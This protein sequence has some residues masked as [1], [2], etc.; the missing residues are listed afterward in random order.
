MPSNLSTSPLPYSDIALQLLGSIHDALF[1]LSDKF[2]AG[3]TVEDKD[4]NSF[5]SWLDQPRKYPITRGMNSHLTTSV[6]KSKKISKDDLPLRLTAVTKSAFYQSQLNIE[7][8]DRYKGLYLPSPLKIL[9]DALTIPNE[10]QSRAYSLITCRNILF[11]LLSI[12]PDSEL[13]RQEGVETFSPKDINSALSK[14]RTYLEH[15]DN[16]SKSNVDFLQNKSGTEKKVTL[17]L[18]HFLAM[19]GILL[20]R[21]GTKG[22]KASYS[23]HDKNNYRLTYCKHGDL[24][25]GDV[26]YEFMQSP[27]YLT[28]PRH[29]ELINQIWGIPLPI[30]G[31]DILFH[32]GLL[33]SS[34]GSLV[35][36]ICGSAGTGKTS[37]ALAIA[38][39]LSPLG[40]STYYITFEENPAD[41]NLRV[42]SL[43]PQYLK[44]LSIYQSDH[45]KWFYADKI[46]MPT[47]VEREKTLRESVTS[48]LE[49]IRE[50][51]HNLRQ[52]RN[53][54][55]IPH[56]CPLVVVIDG[57][58]VLGENVNKSDDL[59]TYDIL[60]ELVVECRKLN[61]MVLLLSGE[62]NHVVTK[63]DYL[64]DTVISL[65]HEG[66]KDSKEKAVRI[67][68]LSKTRQQI[69][70]PGAHVF[71]MSGDDGFRISPQLP[72]QLDNQ[73]LITY[74]LPDE[75]EIIDTLNRYKD[76]SGKHIYNDKDIF[77]NLYNK[78]Q[79]LLH[80]QGS[81][82]KAGLA[83]KI[84]MESTR[85][86]H[87]SDK[88][89]SLITSMHPRRR[90]LI[91]SFLYPNRYYQNLEKNLLKVMFEEND[92]KR[93][94]DL[95]KP[96]IEHLTF[97][98]GYLS[99]EDLIG[100]IIT[101]LKCAE[102]EGEPFTGVLLDGLH[103]VFL[104][105]PAIQK[106]TMIWP[107]IYNVLVRSKVTVV[108][109]F[110]TFPLTD[111]KAGNL[112]NSDLMIEGT[113]PFLQA[114]VQA[115]EFYM[116]LDPFDA[117]DTRVYKLTIK[118]AFKQRITNEVRYWDR[119]GMFFRKDIPEIPKKKNKTSSQ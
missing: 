116:T 66:T 10:L 51:L 47:T 16:Y 52:E 79:I 68:I 84:L 88:R 94:T 19:Q 50:T 44:K 14:L 119:E 2:I 86:T 33:S 112:L 105:F 41:I 24:L 58:S 78:S 1:I 108:S 34:D 71:H 7:S 17:F 18:A 49:K 63:L 75:Y 55:S 83:L 103:N 6:M 29:A 100:K 106:S 11:E 8:A 21:F 65:K 13:V 20:L 92:N 99:P 9:H 64:V 35:M 118:E 72:S 53:N 25:G 45:R 70:R 37:L 5:Y 76:K 113:I 56:I 36:S 80:G 40:T 93:M 48:Q 4:L 62:D 38:S 42:E 117:K 31:A 28:L 59:S 114:L 87:R 60:R 73:H 115:M 91:L 111:S 22:K 101:K 109:T 32:G 57:I 12:Y 82:G 27:D 110:T 67:F 107:M 39:A 89:Q 26:A 3:K 74:H 23:E 15:S 81:S 69:S 96:R 43:I 77:L 90:I 61:V 104:N 102:M 30:R 85:L 95:E 98:P 46:K 54:T 97:F